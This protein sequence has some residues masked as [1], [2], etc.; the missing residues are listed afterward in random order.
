MRVPSG[1]SSG[2][3]PAELLWP[4]DELQ[5][6]SHKACIATC[7]DA[8]ATLQASE[9]ASV[10]SCIKQQV[11]GILARL[12][13]PLAK[14]QMLFNVERHRLMQSVCEADRH[15]QSNSMHDPRLR[16]DLDHSHMEGEGGLDFLTAVLANKKLCED[17]QVGQGNTD[18]IMLAC[19]GLAIN[20]LYD[21]GKPS[22]MVCLR[23]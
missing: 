11:A 13:P 14:K 16:G 23:C 9:S 3:T 8:P 19:E 21:H 15:S 4:L 1:L 7:A 22:N 5:A 17:L 10:I 20:F 2:A 6:S 12:N 18:R